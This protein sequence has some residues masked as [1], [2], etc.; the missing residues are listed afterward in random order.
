MTELSAVPYKVFC[1]RGEKLT[2]KTHVEKGRT[3]LHEAGLHVENASTAISIPDADLVSC[4]ILRLHGLGRVL[5]ID[6]RGGRLFVSVIRLMIGRFAFIN[7][8]K[9]G[10]LN[11]QI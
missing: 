9:T 10:A 6:H 7:F 8:F 11:Q 2:L 4:R 3:W 1:H 5:Q